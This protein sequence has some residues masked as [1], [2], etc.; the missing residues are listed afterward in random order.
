MPAAATRAAVYPQ[1][2]ASQPAPLAPAQAA[3]A[4]APAQAPAPSPAELARQEAARQ[5]VQAE[6][7]EL[8]ADAERRGYHA[9]REQG[10]AAARRELQFQIERFEGLA[11][12][13]TMAKAAV[14]A[15]AED[16]V[17][18]LAFAALCRIL[19]E[20]GATREGV[21]AMVAQCAIGA[22]ERDQVGV[23]LHPDD[24]ALL[25]AAGVHQARFSPD[26]GIVLG[27]CIVDSATGEL[28]AR[29]ETQ[30]ER[31][32]DTL[33]AVRAQRRNPEGAP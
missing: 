24:F 27:G 3:P 6:L 30:L 8:Q 26:P 28:D 32:A 29:L 10:D 33:S 22:R 11:A 2:P 7:A 16:D 1:A 18:E 14:L 31:L 4:P 9:G 17:V 21:L 19:G 20:Q 25:G 23:R 15:D 12:Q 5:Q 13:L